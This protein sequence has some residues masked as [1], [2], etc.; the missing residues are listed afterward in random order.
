MKMKTKLKNSKKIVALALLTA[1]MTTLSAAAKPKVFLMET[2]GKHAKSTRTIVEK[3][4]RDN[5]DANFEMDVRTLTPAE[6][7]QYLST[8]TVE[9]D[10]DIAFIKGAGFLG[11]ADVLAGFVNLDSDVLTT[12]VPA[13]L[14]STENKWFVLAKRARV[15]YYNH[16]QVDLERSDLATY[17]DLSRSYWRED[18]NGEPLYGQICLRHSDKEY[19][20]SLVSFFMQQKGEMA[21]KAMLQNWMLNKPLIKKSDMNGVI[22][23]VQNGECA[24]G[25]ANTYYL[26]HY[27]K[28]IRKRFEEG[29]VRVLFPNQAE[30]QY[31]THM[32]GKIFAVMKRSA[33]PAA[34]Q[35]FLEWFSEAENQ[36]FYANITLEYPVNPKS[37]ALASYP[38]VLRQM[39][40][41]R[42]NKT[43]DWEKAKEQADAALKLMQSLGWKTKKEL[44]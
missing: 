37:A 20:T 18:A 10:G 41:F 6:A 30:G 9:G 43:F 34:A 44:K 17:E 23:A 16:H 38:E 13:H 5:P 11:D 35:R 32:N 33:N 25:I 1:C 39:G 21:T 2:E 24:I 8:G 36:N 26:G 42:E 40:T 7:S 29:A 19:N 27:L 4:N 12:N 14:R 31:G 28:S 3:F 22:S 15:I